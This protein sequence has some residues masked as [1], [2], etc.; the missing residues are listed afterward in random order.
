MQS[1]YSARMSSHLSGQQ[2]PPFVVSLGVCALMLSISAFAQNAPAP[3]ETIHD[4]YAVHL[5]IHI[6]GHISD[7]N[8]SLPMYDTLVNV[9][10]GPRILQQSLEMHAVSGAKHF[11]LYDT[12]LATS[13]G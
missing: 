7:E 13:V 11:F 8:G 10:S 9:H 3:K 4:G 1:S 12:L 5:S 6:G 2:P